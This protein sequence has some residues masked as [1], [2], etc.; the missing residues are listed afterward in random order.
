MLNNKDVVAFR[1]LV[2]PDNL[3]FLLFSTEL[4]VIAKPGDVIAGRTLRT[5][6][7]NVLADYASMNDDGRVVFLGTFTDGSQAI[8]L[9][10][11]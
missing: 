3:N 1:A 10:T 6:G 9:A 8:I 5:V 2:G 7:R 11:P 4:G